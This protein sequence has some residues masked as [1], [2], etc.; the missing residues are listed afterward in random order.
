MKLKCE[1]IAVENN[2]DFITVTLQ[3]KARRA[4]EWRD[5][6]EQKLRIPPT[7]ANR[8]AFYIGRSVT[9]DVRT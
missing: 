3:G 4:A 8:S 7:P 5:L 2:G 9:I 6:V 1:V